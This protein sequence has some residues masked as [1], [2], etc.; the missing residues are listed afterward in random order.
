MRPLSSA[1]EIASRYG[2]ATDFLRTFAIQNQMKY[3]EDSVRC[4]M[5]NAPTMSQ[6]EDAYG[7]K[8]VREWI[9][10]QLANL[11]EYFGGNGKITIGQMDDLSALMTQE[12][13]AQR[14]TSVMLFFRRVK[15]GR[16]GKFY[17][18]FDPM[19]FMEMWRAF[20]LDV[21]DIIEGEERRREAARIEDMKRRAVP[22]EVIR[23]R[24]ERGEYKNLKRFF[25]GEGD[26]DLLRDQ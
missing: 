21:V 6:V 1:S 7:R 5:G 23:E 10:Y 4:V 3:T 11:S 25:D 9:T 17:G 14:I 18:A 24:M 8:V 26:Y 15:A 22:M 2:S 12:C 20:L 16:Y 19:Q 13:R